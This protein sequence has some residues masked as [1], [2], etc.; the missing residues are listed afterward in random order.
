MG[1]SWSGGADF[2]QA[3]GVGNYVLD[4]LTVPAG[5]AL[6]PAAMLLVSFAFTTTAN[7]PLPV[8]EV[9]FVDSGGTEHQVNGNYPIYGF[10]GGVG[11]GSSISPSVSVAGLNGGGHIR[12][13]G[14]FGSAD[15]IVGTIVAAIWDGAGAN[16]FMGNGNSKSLTGGTT[17]DTGTGGGYSTSG[18][19]VLNLTGAVAG[20]STASPASAPDFTPGASWA[21]VI[22]RANGSLFV[23]L[24][25]FNGTLPSVFG[26]PVPYSVSFS[27]IDA[28]L[29]SG[30]LLVENE[31]CDLGRSRSFAAII[32]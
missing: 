28:G 5:N 23:G 12:L 19:K 1:I 16:A 24:G 21:N 8:T 14:F 22:G 32:D 9:D 13:K 15:T 7:N 4:T 30:Q 6:G 31:E 17:S 18:H 26:F 27:T 3:S 11:R 2:S 25:I 20:Y 10:A 29:D